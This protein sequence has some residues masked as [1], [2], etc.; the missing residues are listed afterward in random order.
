MY[1]RGPNLYKFSRKSDNIWWDVFVF[2][3]DSS[4]CC[5]CC[6]NNSLRLS[7]VHDLL[8]LPTESCLYNEINH[9]IANKHY[10]FVKT[11]ASVLLLVQSIANKVINVVYHM[12]EL[13]LFIFFET[14]KY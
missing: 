9:Q 4:W 13:I 7:A 10:V 11:A 14:R 1:K 12:Y 2:A 8:V 3:F 5:C 6:C